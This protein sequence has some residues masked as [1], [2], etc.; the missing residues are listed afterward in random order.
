[1]CD[2]KI[3]FAV[4]LALAN[5]PLLR[6]FG[7]SL[8]HFVV[9]LCQDVNAFNKCLECIPLTTDGDH[10]DEEDSALEKTLRV[11]RRRVLVCLID[12]DS[13]GSKCQAIRKYFNSTLLK[14]PF[15]RYAYPVGW[16]REEISFPAQV[17]GFVVPLYVGNI[18]F[19]RDDI[20]SVIPSEND[21][22]KIGERI[23]CLRDEGI[24]G[25]ALFLRAAIATAQGSLTVQRYEQL[26]EAV[27][28]FCEG[29]SPK[30]DLVEY[31]TTCI[32]EWGDRN[33]GF[34][35]PNS[36]SG[37]DH[38]A[39]SKIILEDGNYIYIGSSLYKAWIKRTSLLMKDASKYLCA[40]GVLYPENKTTTSCR[41]V[42]GK[43]GSRVRMY[44]FLK[45][46]ILKYRKDGVTN[47][48]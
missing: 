10:L 25:F 14:N 44:R 27:T 11:Q 41:V 8:D 46:K 24:E 28:D 12:S 40:E 35:K 39:I 37:D 26:C 20:E 34:E 4:I 23:E 33:G 21:F 13:V 1:M 29:L 19:S 18:S 2:E 30:F 43:N 47:E 7:V 16:C 6:R 31:M 48:Q 36:V 5:E 15:D 32:N 9:F 17:L 42:I 45:E 22:P 38:D 3:I